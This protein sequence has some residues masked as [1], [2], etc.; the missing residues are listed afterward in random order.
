[1]NLYHRTVTIYT[2]L[3][4]GRESEQPI[5]QSE[6]ESMIKVSNKEKPL[7]WKCYDFQSFFHPLFKA[8]ICW[9]K[10]AKG[11]QC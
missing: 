8:W 9:S 2:F 3:D 11:Q 7:D 10:A 6:G 4:I 5:P 1:V